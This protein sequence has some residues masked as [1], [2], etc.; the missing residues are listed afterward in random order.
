MPTEI[1]GIVD[2]VWAL[3]AKN[4]VFPSQDMIANIERLNA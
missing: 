2:M 4:L 3:M 1:P